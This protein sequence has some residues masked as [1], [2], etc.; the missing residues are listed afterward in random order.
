MNARRRFGRF[1]F[2]VKRSEDGFTFEVKG[3]PEYYQVRQEVFRLI[4][5]A[6][7]EARRNGVTL[8]EILAH[9][10]RGGRDRDNPPAAND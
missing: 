10:A 7:R 1:E 2:H 9:L 5:D 4:D 8:A 6:V 3:D